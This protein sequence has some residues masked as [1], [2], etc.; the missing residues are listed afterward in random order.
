MTKILLADNHKLL[1]DGL[2]SLLERLSDIEISGVALDG[3]EAVNLAL[4]DHPDIILMDISMP[5]LNGLDATRKILREL[6]QT[7]IIILSMHDDRRYIEEALRFGA[8]GYVLK[9]SAVNEVLEAIRRVRNGGLFFSQ[10][11][12]DQVLRD[13]IH[14]I[15]DDV[16][17]LSS[18]LSVRER[19]V[20]QLLAEGKSTKDMAG[21]LNVSIKTI[22]SHRKKIMDKLNL[23][24]IAELTKYAVREGLTPLE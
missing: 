9:E 6:P 5:R 17:P 14:S 22:E 18:P 4:R 7:K 1:I 24:S 13:Y 20:L 10:A 11:V 8:S 19:E 2:R 21:E 3:I 16:M 12:R 15:R 23:H